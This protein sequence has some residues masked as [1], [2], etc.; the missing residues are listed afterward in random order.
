MLARTGSL[1]RAQDNHERREPVQHRNV[2]VSL[3]SNTIWQ[4][5]TT[6]RFLD[7]VCHA[8]ETDDGANLP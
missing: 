1:A 6:E 4:V 7:F 8:K 3:A 2:T 5:K